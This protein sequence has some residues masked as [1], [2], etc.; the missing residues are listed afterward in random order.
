MGTDWGI[1]EPYPSPFMKTRQCKAFRL[2]IL[3]INFCLRGWSLA[4]LGYWLGVICFGGFFETQSLLLWHNKFLQWV[5]YLHSQRSAY[6][7]RPFGWVMSETYS[8]CCSGCPPQ[9]A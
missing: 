3:T 1:I 5:Y 8:L 7:M 9:Q 6:S 2:C 4:W